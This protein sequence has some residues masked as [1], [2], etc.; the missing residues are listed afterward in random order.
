MLKLESTGLMV[1]LSMIPAV[2]NFIVFSP[3]RTCRYMSFGDLFTSQTSENLTFTGFK[4]DFENT[5]CYSTS[6]RVYWFVLYVLEGFII[7]IHLLYSTWFHFIFV[8][9]L[10]LFYTLTSKQSGFKMMAIA[11]K[12]FFEK[13]LLQKK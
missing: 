4:I 13:I 8:T 2:L 6:L 9:A 11:M 12:H 10:F 3:K 5:Q 1:L 7:T